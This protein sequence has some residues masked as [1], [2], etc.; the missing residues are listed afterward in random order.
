MKLRR[1]R[2]GKLT[3]GKKYEKD[4]LT[5]GRDDVTSK[6]SSIRTKRYVQPRDKRNIPL[7][8]AFN[9]HKSVNERN[10]KKKKNERHRK[11]TDKQSYNNDGERTS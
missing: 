11:K 8:R 2:T 10:E 7:P 5:D 1:F 6:L 4:G 9:D 3:W